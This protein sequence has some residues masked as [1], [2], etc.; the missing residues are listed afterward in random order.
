MQSFVP[1]THSEA[2]PGGSQSFGG[3][4][5]F[6]AT[7]RTERSADSVIMR[8]AARQ[9][10]VVHRTQLVASG[11]SRHQIALRLADERL[12]ELHRGVYLVGAVAPEHAHEQ[13]ALF[14]CGPSAVLS[15]RSAVVLWRLAEKS[16]AHRVPSVT[17]PTAKRIRRPGLELHRASLEPRDF[18][19]RYG[20]RLTSPPRTLLDMAALLDDPYE[21]EALVAEASY[22]NLASEHELH[23]QIERNR[24]RPGVPALRRVV[25]I[26]GGPQRTRSKG[27]RQFL[28]LLRSHGINGYEANSKIYGWEVDFL[29]PELSF[30]VEVD[31][32]DGHKGRAA[33]ERDRLKWAELK[34]QGVDLMPVTGRQMRDDADAVIGR[35]ESALEL[36]RAQQRRQ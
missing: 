24:R 4:V 5:H 18:R 27:E 9:H 33:F 3:V 19:S 26:P 8:L 32:W 2:D 17:V 12:R 29:W 21:L 10:A 36:A 6:V 28:R 11:V 13:A 30:G 23:E 14:A 34:A 31:G 1:P 15:H 7:L 22:R 16:A 25:A 20:L 35:L